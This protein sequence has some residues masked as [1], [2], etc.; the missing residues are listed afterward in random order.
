[1]AS[2]FIGWGAKIV[3]IRMGAQG[4]YLTTSD[5]GAWHIPAVAKKIVDVTGAGNAYCGGMLVGVANGIDLPEA[6]LRASVSASFALEQFGVPKFI[7]NLEDETMSRLIW[8][9]NNINDVN[10]DS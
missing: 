5:G 3:A 1:M 7:D 6:A 9:R 10:I 2:V 4:S 8:A